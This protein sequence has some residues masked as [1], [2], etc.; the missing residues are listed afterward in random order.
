MNE[1]VFQPHESLFFRD[2][3]PMGGANAGHGARFPEPHVLNGALHAA[4]HRAFGDDDSV[5]YAHGFR[6]RERE[7]A[8]AASERFGSLRSVGP[9]PVA[10]NGQWYMPAPAD[11]LSATDAEPSLRVLNKL[12]YSGHSS[13]PDGLQPIAATRPAEKTTAPG[14][15][16]VGAF[17]DYLL[18][19]PLAEGALTHNSNFFVAEHAVGIG[20]D[21]ATGSNSHG[22][23]Y[24]RSAMRF[25]EGCSLGAYVESGNQHGAENDLIERMFPAPGLIRI[26]GEGRTCSVKRSTTESLN[27]LPQ[28][29]AIEGCRVKWVLLSP[30]IFP[31]LGPTERHPETAEHPGGWLP[32]WVQPQSLEVKLL[33]GP[34]RNKAQRLKVKAGAPIE[35]RLVAALVR[36]RQTISGWA[37][38][39]GSAVEERGQGARSTLL[40]VPAGSIYYFEASNPVQAQKLAAAL[41][42]HGEQNNRQLCNRRST[43]LGEKG[44][45]IG[46]CGPWKAL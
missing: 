19:R 11:F 4:C 33:D 2:S 1:L 18:G 44:F 8:E 13:L 20:I 24:T 17:S 30:C 12:P 36:S 34:G 6:N 26:G 15:L 5:S 45:G 40:A 21:S 27:H 42:W 23:I 9:F 22:K 43:L 31:A 46:V 39:A 3:R 37:Q 7:R 14:W 16:A 35:A 41:N 10:A 29:A 32:T 25:K 28:G 38:S